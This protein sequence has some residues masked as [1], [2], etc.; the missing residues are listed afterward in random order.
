M[1]GDFDAA[2]RPVR[3]SAFRQRDPGLVP[4]DV[5]DDRGFAGTRT[6]RRF[7]GFSG[8]GLPFPDSSG[9]RSASGNGGSV[10]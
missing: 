3:R 1:N 6:Q 2:A 10:L 7:S 4:S 5:E 8:F 9:M